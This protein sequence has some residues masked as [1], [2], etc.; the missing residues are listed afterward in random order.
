MY[1]SILFFTLFNKANIFA[2]LGGVIASTKS[3]AKSHA[4]TFKGSN[5]GAKVDLIPLN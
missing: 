1:V 4:P 3:F 2:L 5:A